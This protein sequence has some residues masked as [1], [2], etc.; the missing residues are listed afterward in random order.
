MSLTNPNNAVT[1]QRLSEFYQEILPYLNG[2]E[3]NYKVYGIRILRDESVPSAKVE[4]LADAIGMTPAHMDYENDIFDYG[5]W[6]NAFFMPKPCMLKY[7]GTVDYYLDPNDYTKKEDGTASD[8]ANTSYQGN[9]MMEWPKIWLKIVPDAT[10]D[11][12][13]ADIF[14]S[15]VQVDENYTDWPYHNS[16]GESVEHFYTSI[17]HGCNLSNKIRSLSGQKMGNVTATDANNEKTRTE[18]NNPSG[19]YI[20]SMINISD[21]ELIT[22]LLMLISKSTDSQTS[23]GYGLRSLDSRDIVSG[24]QNAKGLFYGKQSSSSTADIVKIFGMENWWGPFFYRYL[25]EV[26]I[27]GGFNRKL[28]YGTEDGS[29]TTGYNFT[30]SGYISENIGTITL[31]SG[32]TQYVTL[33]NNAY[34]KDLFF[35]SDG[36]YPSSISDGSSSTYYCD[37]IAYDTRTGTKIPMF[38]GSGGGG[39]GADKTS[40]Y[41]AVGSF[42]KSYYYGYGQ[43]YH[44]ITTKLSARP[45]S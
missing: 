30:G 41:S 31:P 19:S 43:S 9:A 17:Y 7:D 23:F 38:G 25:G 29:T 15:N 12:K 28:T 45:L 5:S 1:A 8:V 13:E 27:N 39:G 16:L 42:I 35:T 14:I 44:T 2:P 40:S 21:I 33:S 34:I 37:I 4:Y 20:W 18:A 10:K 3:P 22:I 24:V 11:N 32:S 26:I 36:I 6:E